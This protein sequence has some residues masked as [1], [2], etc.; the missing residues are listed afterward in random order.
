[1]PIMLATYIH[2]QNN[3]HLNDMLIINNRGARPLIC[4]AD[5]TART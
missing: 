2:K 4:F 3:N 1:M 5:H